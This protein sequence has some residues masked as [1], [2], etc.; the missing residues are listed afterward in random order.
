MLK[1]QF[2][3]AEYASVAQPPS[4]GCVLKLIMQ[5][6]KDFKNVQP[7]SGGC[8]LKQMAT[9]LQKLKQR[10]Q[11]PSGG[12]VLK[13]LDGIGLATKTVQPPSGGC[14][15]KLDLRTFPIQSYGQPPSGGCVLKL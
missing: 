5:V 13:P 10:R 7:P 12:C 3:G 4:G 9:Q 2:F 1:R 8:V 15:L 11:P 14:V 6:E